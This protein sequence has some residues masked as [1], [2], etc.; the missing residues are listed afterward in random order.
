[1]DHSSGYSNFGRSRL[2][3][4]L[5]ERTG[6]GN[7]DPYSAIEY[8]VDKLRQAVGDTGRVKDFEQYLKLRKVQLVPSSN[9]RCDGYIQPQGKSSSQGFTM[10]VNR[11]LPPSRIR[12]TIAHEICHTIFYEI[13]PELKFRWHQT[14]PAEERLCDFGAA[15][16]LMPKDEVVRA[17]QGVTPSMAALEKLAEHYAVSLEAM[18]LRI[19][20]LAGWKC[21][22]VIW[23][24]TNDG[25]FLADRA[26]RPFEKDW[27]WVDS[28]IPKA[29]WE[30]KKSL[31]E[32]TFVHFQDA[33]KYW[34]AQRIHFQA[35]RRANS[36]VTLWSQQPL[37]QPTKPQ[38]PMLNTAQL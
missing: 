18:F 24:R 38:F 11:T 10:F 20:R 13:I 12:F 17:T 16:L 19:Q 3:R 29:A 8:H 6:I 37:L 25:R 9:L 4:L 22:L 21:Q 15:A 30:G 1:M 5:I 32:W 14:D 28:S 33:R 27:N 23:H 31:P 2:V 7:T 36:L 35:K 26:Y 34:F